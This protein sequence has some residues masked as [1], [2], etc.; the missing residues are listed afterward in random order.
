MT[1]CIA[2][3]CEER[4]TNDK[5]IL[6]CAD[7]R[8]EYGVSSNDSNRKIGKLAHGWIG[9]LSGDFVAASELHDWIK[10][11][12]LAGVPADRTALHG[13]LVEASR[14]FMGTPFHKKNAIEIMVCGFAG[15]VPTIASVSVGRASSPTVEFYQT[16]HASGSG[17]IIAEVFMNLRDLSPRFSIDHA[18][19]IV[20]EAKRY[21]EKNPGVGPQTVLLA[22]RPRT[23]NAGA[24]E[25]GIYALDV[26]A[27]KEMEEA[28]VRYGVKEIEEI[29]DSVRFTELSQ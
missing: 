12:I 16:F 5:C 27:M 22:M 7:T 19:Y 24:D 29:P 11:G 1:V 6:L 10:A 21:S 9:M 2:A 28:R 18:A 23:V 26:G 15:N 4:G 20:Y 25:F 14:G 13:V 17:A 8:L 3:I